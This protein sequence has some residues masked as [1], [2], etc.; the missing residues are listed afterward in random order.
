[1]PS[2][3]PFDRKRW[4]LLLIDCLLLAVAT[5]ITQWIV[6]GRFYDIFSTLTGGSLITIVLYLMMIY[7]FDLYNI[8]RPFINQSTAFRAA[9]AVI[10]AGLLAMSVFYA[11]PQYRYGRGLF[12]AQMVIVWCFIFG[13]RCI[14]NLT[15]MNREVKRRILVIGAGKAAKAFNDLINTI[16]SP[17]QI[18][19]FL[20]D[21]LNP[22]GPIEELKPILGRTNQLIEVAGTENIS[23]AVLAITH[24]RPPALVRNIL[25]ARLKGVNITDMP[26]VYEDL[27]GA[28][29]VGHLRYDWLLFA[30]GFNLLSKHFIRKIKR[31]IDFGVSGL[32]LVATAPVMLITAIA[33]RKDSPGPVFYRQKR[34]GHNER[35]FT[36]WKFRSMYVESDMENINK[37]V[38]DEEKR[39]TPVGRWI[40]KLRIDELPQIINVFQG[41]M[42]LI[43][44]RPEQ[45]GFVE[46]LQK[47]LP[48]YRV[49]H[50]VAPGIT[51]W[52]QVKYH[53]AASTEESL[54]K[55][56]YD[57]YYIK[58]MSLILDARIMLKTIRVVFFG[59]GAR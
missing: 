52:A 20:D 45:P 50:Y 33:I 22:Q 56:E 11:I 30:D 13:W 55:L 23:K 16:D 41:E 3:F 48:Y 32:L 43:G 19:G 26:A 39:I 17:Y 7:I 37:W 14:F 59:H 15:F 51:G 2:P 9:L 49:R 38:N 25:E 4:L 28:I 42:S 27:T 12:L 36:I 57:I 29:P 24:H 54:K 40:R 18:I 44:P 53:Y 58:N 8:R 21:N 6:F 35:V 34:V 46:E 10:C 1:M 47:L 31:L 5:K